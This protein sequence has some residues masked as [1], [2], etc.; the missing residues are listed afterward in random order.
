MTRMDANEKERSSAFF[1]VLTGA[2]AARGL[3]VRFRLGPPED[4][5][6][7]N[8]NSRLFAFIRGQVLPPDGCDD[9]RC[10]YA[11]RTGRLRFHSL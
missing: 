7:Q 9:S 8:E 6:L 5:F 1:L 10:R 11:W 4:F 2:G 3:S